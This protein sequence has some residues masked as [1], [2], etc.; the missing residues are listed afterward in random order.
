MKK[1]V[2]LSAGVLAGFALFASMPAA[3]A[4]HVDVTIGLPGVYVEPMYQQP[5]V[6]YVQP[7]P[8]YIQPEQEYEWRSRHERARHWR[9]NRER[10]DWHED[11]DRH[12]HRDNGRGHGHGHE[13]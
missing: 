2:A 10:R 5:E 13:D 6:V 8:I 9:E 3:S 1:I 11:N 7:R 4:A 12:D